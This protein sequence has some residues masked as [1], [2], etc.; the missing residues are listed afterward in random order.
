MVPEWQGTTFC[1]PV[2]CWHARLQNGPR[3]VIRD[4]SEPCHTFIIIL[5]YRYLG[6]WVTDRSIGDYGYILMPTSQPTNR[7]LEAC[8][9]YVLNTYMEYFDGLPRQPQGEDLSI[10]DDSDPE[11]YSQA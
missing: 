11:A 5:M 2:K 10:L 6:G 1:I 4:Y 3:D 8:L 9:A 7:L